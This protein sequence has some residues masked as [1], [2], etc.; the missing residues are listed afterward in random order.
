MLEISIR[1]NQELKDK[2]YQLEN[3][4]EN[5]KRQNDPQ[6][7]QSYRSDGRKSLC[8]ER[9]MRNNTDSN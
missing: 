2:N 4:F 5:Y 3:D 8:E 6:S 7:R 1:K 9:S